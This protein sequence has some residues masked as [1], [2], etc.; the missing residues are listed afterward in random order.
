MKDEMK[1]ELDEYDRVYYRIEALE[2]K[3]DI[4]LP[5]FFKEYRT[6]AK[7]LENKVQ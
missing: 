6:V 7:K 1:V 2:Q 5:G 4:V 3:K